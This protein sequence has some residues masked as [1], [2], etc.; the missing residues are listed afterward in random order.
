MSYFLGIDLGASSLKASLVDGQARQLAS[1]SAP[2][3]SVHPQAGQVEQNP[4]D[5]LSALCHVLAS[6]Q[7]TQENSFSQ[8]E[9]I[10]FSGGAHIAVLQGADGAVLRPAIMWSDQRAHEEA[11]FLQSQNV[12]A[13]TRNRPNPTWSLPQL[14]WLQKHQPEMMQKC[15]RISFAKDWLRSQL[16]GDWQTDASEAVGALLTDYHNATQHNEWHD[17][18]LAYAGLSPQ[19]M[20]PLA[21]MLSMA[22][23]VTQSAAQQTGL[24]VGTPVYQ[25]AI[26][27]TIE[28]L[29]CAPLTAGTASLKLASAGVLAFGDTSA[30]PHPPVSLYPHILPDTHYHAAGMNN[31][32]GALH[33][34]RQLYLSDMDLHEM[35]AL[36]Q[37]APMGS[38]GVVFYPYL[39]GERAPLWDASR[40]ASLCGL[41]RGTTRADIARAAYEGIGH[42]L[43]EIFQDM[44]AKIGVRPDRLHLLGGGA[45]DA[46]WGQMLAD[47]MNVEI[48]RGQHTDCSF[49]TALMAMTADG[50]FADVT[51]AAAAG[52]Q[53]AA[54][55][56]PD[57]S[58]TR[59]Y[60]DFHDLFI[61]QRQQ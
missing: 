54:H 34:V 38:N 21:D 12:E 29:C 39:N 2:I 44:T 3:A 14:I 32:M 10:C 61:A 36:A 22:G 33:W 50:A 31:C 26:D 60:A 15:H 55:F 25:G 40:T 37:T 41:S 30:K 42:A 4:A 9:A 56:T 59:G 23:H 49:A 18:L 46:F 45:Q 7:H 51:E 28:W 17:D 48:A 11:S 35:Q 8:I 13:V 16:T 24:K 19:H 47:M 58:K 43:N 53:H 1:A 57:K 5:W 52:Y 20:P 27:T 6:L